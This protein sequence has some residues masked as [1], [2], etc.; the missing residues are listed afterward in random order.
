MLQSVLLH[1]HCVCL[2]GRDMTGHLAFH[3][4]DLRQPPMQAAMRDVQNGDQAPTDIVG[5]YESFQWSICF[6]KGSQKIQ[7][8]L[9]PL[10][11]KKKES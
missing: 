4:R 5:C 1:H 2:G 8:I 6:L 3:V 11:K 9:L 10:I 7:K